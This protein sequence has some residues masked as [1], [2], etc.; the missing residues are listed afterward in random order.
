MADWIDAIAQRANI[1]RDAVERVH[2]RYSIVPSPALPT[3]TR[4]TLSRVAFSGVK[5]LAGGDTP[6]AFDW[7]LETGIWAAITDDANLRGKSTIIEVIRWALR[8][9]HD[10]QPDVRSWLRT[11]ELDLAVSASDYVIRIDT[12]GQSTAGSIAT[13]E[14]T[15]IAAFAS[16]AEFEAAAEDFLMP[17]L[18]LQ[19]LAYYQQAAGGEPGARGTQGWVALADGL[20]I[21]STDALLGDVL[22]SGLPGRLLQ[23]YL[24]IPW[25][26][27]LAAAKAAQSELRALGRARPEPG[28]RGAAP[29]TT[30]MRRDL[31]GRLQDLRRQLLAMPDPADRVTLRAAALNALATVDRT[32]LAAQQLVNAV[33][34]EFDAVS[35]SVLDQERKLLDMTETGELKRFFNGLEPKICPR[36]DVPVGRDRRVREARE[37]SCSL[38]GE[39]VSREDDATSLAQVGR[40]LTN[41]R[42][43]QSEVQDRLGLA[44]AALERASAQRA[45][46]QTAAEA[47]TGAVDDASRREV[48]FQIARLEGQLEGLLGA[49]GQIEG[50]P[51][52]DPEPLVINET[53]RELEHRISE[54][55]TGLFAALDATVARNGRMFGI[56]NLE[57]ATLD[58]AGHLRLTKG[59]ARVSYSSLTGGEKLRMKIAVVV[60]LVSVG[61]DLGVGRYPGLLL[62]D[63][64]GGHETSDADL[65]AIFRGLHTLA[66][67]I[68][69]MQVII[70]TARG[71]VAREFVAGD[72]LREPNATGYLW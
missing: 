10:L 2:A 47:A 54:G 23:V 19:R 33:I 48:E 59:G 11:V 29:A 20:H 8:G 72:H 64:P 27:T 6:F 38:C 26:S 17:K 52:G 7:P 46:A 67:E 36:C 16:D 49:T 22:M 53:V 40:D 35:E 50:N 1:D 14:G 70:A 69:T 9:R 66:D 4:V 32:W 24:G 44:V 62:I 61:R 43:A 3:P 51:P 68:P 41:L 31:D 55:Q 13:N 71:T 63:A 28:A 25:A 57:A 42:E 34:S 60:A 39:G 21:H 58:R 15:R 45:S 37:G 18:G 56:E 12:D 30:A 5:R 65:R